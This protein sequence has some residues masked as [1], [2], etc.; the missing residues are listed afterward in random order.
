MHKAAKAVAVGL[1]VCVWLAAPAGAL[2]VSDNDIFL[3]G[4]VIR[5]GTELDAGSLPCFDPMR[6]GN[7][8]AQDPL[9]KLRYKLLG[10]QLGVALAPKFMAPAETL[11]YNGFQVSI[12]TS[13][14]TFD[15]TEDYWILGTE[16]HNAGTFNGNGD[17]GL[18]DATSIMVRKGLPW[19]L[20]IAA[21]GSYL[22]NS[23]IATGNLQIK[24]SVF[25]GFHDIAGGV[26]K[27]LPDIAVRGSVARAIGTGE[28]DLTVSGVDISISKP[29]GIGHMWSLTP[30]AG[31]SYL[32]VSLRSE[33]VDF[34]PEVPPGKVGPDGRFKIT[35][36]EASHNDVFQDEDIIVPGRF[37]GGFRV[38]YTRFSFVAEADY[39]PGLKELAPNVV[40]QDGTSMDVSVNGKAQWTFSFGIAADF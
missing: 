30:F 15:R 13:L 18:L 17:K 31:W 19:G 14:T 24:W 16:R 39:T 26:G 35:G 11:G 36:G 27:F 40:L 38:I 8:T 21:G 2:A 22:A 1:G 3:S 12:E 37:F 6:M 33:V 4:L 23:E 28:L 32:I 20:E 7:P 34:T 10:Y 25:E 5:C 29:F 9:S